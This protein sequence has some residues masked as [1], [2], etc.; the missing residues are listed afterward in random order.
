MTADHERKVR[1]ALMMNKLAAYH[2]IQNQMGRAVVAANFGQPE[3]LL[4]QFALDHPDV[5]LEVAD[6][7]RFVGREAVA[8]IVE[9]VVNRPEQPG[10]MTDI[11]LT[12][13]IIEVADDLGSA[14]ALWWT[15]GAGALV[16]GGRDPRAVW[17]WGMI[18]ADF[19]LLDGE[20]KILHAHYFR[21]IKCDY[22]K[23]WV[24]DLSM[25]NRPQRPMHPMS[26]PTTYH[27]PYSPMT[28]RDGLPAAPRP[29]PTYDGFDWRLE[30][31]KAK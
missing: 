19:I 21:Y 4:A 23:G 3:T 8:A 25:V 11:Q 31:D 5:S 12:T 14:R 22:S 26:S 16:E 1:L 28:I 15:A 10:A 2:E 30:R 18:A 27:N 6:E 24:E 13:P 7:G 17:L 9:L 29:Y 20:W